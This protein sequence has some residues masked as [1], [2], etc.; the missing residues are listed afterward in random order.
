MDNL[1]PIFSNQFNSQMQITIYQM[2]SKM[3]ERYLKRL[4]NGDSQTQGQTNT[5]SVTDPLAD[6]NVGGGTP[7]SNQKFSYTGSDSSSFASIIKTAAQRYGVDE[8]LVKSVIQVESNF[9]PNAVSAAG[10]LGLMQLMPG[11]ASGL[12]VSNPLDPAQNVDGGV[13]FLRQLLDRFGGNIDLA[14]AGYNAGP[15]AVAQYG[16]IPPYA[17]TQAYVQRV[18]SYL[19]TQSEW[20]G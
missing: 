20:R 14:L 4:E 8:A 10:A 9:N 13:K 18:K 12:G 15:G 17:E 5:S 3:M 1:G 6:P 16:G 2:I 19:S 7:Y 11:T